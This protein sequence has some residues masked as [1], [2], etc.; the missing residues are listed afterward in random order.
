MSVEEKQPYMDEAKIDKERF[1]REVKE[2]NKQQPTDELRLPLLKKKS[3]KTTSEV[4]QK[5]KSMASTVTAEP[6]KPTVSIPIPSKSSSEF[7]NCELPIFTDTFL[8]HNK[9]IEAEL[10]MLRRSNLEMDQQN[11]LLMKHVENM[12]NGVR[13]VEAEIAKELQQNNQYVIYL[14]KLKCSLSSRLN[15]LA[16]P[17]FPVASVENIENYLSE[18]ST[19][20]ISSPSLLNKANDIIRKTD[21]KFTH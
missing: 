9:C 8:D 2:F 19:A 15:S 12:D 4:A 11:S 10:K 21:L 14:T 3:K 7:L 16:V 1:K 13:K 17:G 5:D 6:S 18:L 20:A